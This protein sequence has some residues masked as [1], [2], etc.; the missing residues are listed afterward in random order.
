MIII[1]K[2]RYIKIYIIYNNM[3]FIENNYLNELK[4]YTSVVNYKE[5]FDNL[6][7][8]VKNDLTLEMERMYYF[9][10]EFEKEEYEYETINLSFYMDNIKNISD[11]YI[12]IEIY[13]TSYMY[14]DLKHTKLGFTV[15][16]KNS[17]EHIL[18]YMNFYKYNICNNEL[19][20]CIYN[21]L[22]YIHIL[23]RDFNFNSLFNHFYH[24][25]D[26]P[27]MKKIRD[28]NLRLFG[29][30]ETEC[31]VCLETCITKT[32]CNHTLCYK[33]YSKLVKKICPSCREPL[34]IECEEIIY[35]IPN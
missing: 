15:Y 14:N 17:R 35:E 9:F 1:Y 29:D 8:T 32:Y 4:G 12:D 10:T 34:E 16:L 26:I 11:I 23:L 6:N 5:I 2:K 3:E 28:R 20:R 30:I 31:S 22:F 33:C 21:L 18:Q 24:K 25:D 27:E 7:N 13:F 19:K